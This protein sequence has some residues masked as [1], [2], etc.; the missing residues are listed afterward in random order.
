[1]RIACP[2]G[3]GLRGLCRWSQLRCIRFRARGKFRRVDRLPPGPLWFREGWKRQIVLWSYELRFCAVKR[4]QVS[5]EQRQAKAG[6]MERCDVR[7][8][9]GAARATEISP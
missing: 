5:P 8:A 1:M 2:A 3:R 9:Q 7:P 4:L 6:R